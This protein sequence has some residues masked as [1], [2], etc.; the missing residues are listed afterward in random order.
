MFYKPLSHRCISNTACQTHQHKWHHCCPRGLPALF[1]HLPAPAVETHSSGP[2][3]IQPELQNDHVAS[4]FRCPNQ[5][6]LIAARPGH[7]A[8]HHS[9]FQHLS[10]VQRSHVFKNKLL[11]QT[12]VPTLRSC[13]DSALHNRVSLPCTAPHTSVLSK[14]QGPAASLRLWKQGIWGTKVHSLFSA[15]SAICTGCTLIYCTP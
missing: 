14:H 15:T 1:L 11:L 2:E 9:L 12:D 10:V 8:G 7:M 13:S 5:G 6:H 3:Q 4:G